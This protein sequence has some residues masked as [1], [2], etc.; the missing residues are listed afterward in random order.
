[1]KLVGDDNDCG[2]DPIKNGCRFE[3]KFNS[4]GSFVTE[5]NIPANLGNND[6]LIPLY[7]Y[8]YPGA[9]APF[10]LKGCFHDDPQDEMNLILNGPV[11]FKYK[12]T[13]TV[14][15]YKDQ[16]VLHVFS[17]SA[18]TRSLDERLVST[19]AH[20]HEERLIVPLSTCTGDQT[21]VNPS[22]LAEVESR[23]SFKCSVPPCA[24]HVVRIKVQVHKR[25]PNSE[26]DPVASSQGS[27]YTLWT[28]AGSE[29]VSEPSSTS[30]EG[31]RQNTDVNVAIQSSQCHPLNLQSLVAIADEK[32]QVD[33]LGIDSQLRTM[34]VGPIESLREEVMDCNPEEKDKIKPY[35]M[36]AVPMTSDG[37]KNV[38]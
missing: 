26:K 28:D 32:F 16:E 7:I 4:K 14:L 6:Q 10:I 24:Y 38:S 3:G 8:G 18:A 5:L 27:Q 22:R 33:V 35:P 12:I 36:F 2:E 15:K 34:S 31:Q 11:G 17:K 13:V 20:D 19:P 23:W 21:R 1:M 29:N 37:E 30:S 9:P 25:R